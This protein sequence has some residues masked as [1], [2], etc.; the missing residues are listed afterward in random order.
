MTRT[1][2]VGN[3][4]PKTTEPELEELFAGVGKVESVSIARDYM[5]GANKDFG[6]IAMDTIETAR[7]AVVEMSGHLLH[8]RPLKVTEILESGERNP[9]LDAQRAEAAL[10]PTKRG[11]GAK[12]SPPR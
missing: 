8:G 4:S 11:W 6:F 3:L 5:T 2:F 7:K 10:N 1:L 12:G 9:A